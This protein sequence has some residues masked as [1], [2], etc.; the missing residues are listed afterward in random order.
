MEPN[1]ISFEEKER[2]TGAA[3]NL[4]KAR[5]PEY[6]PTQAN[7]DK[8]ISFIESQLGMSILEYPYPL[9]VDNFE[10]A[11]EHIL[12]TSWFY[13]REPEV[14]VEDPAVVKE[15]QAQE[16]VR[17][18]YDVQQA[19]AKMQRDRNMPLSELGKIVGVQNADFRAQR[20][21]NKL[22]VRSTGMESR[23]VEQVKLGIPAQAR[24]NVGLANPGLDTHSAEFTKKYAAELARLRG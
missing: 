5:H 12:A 19:A 3:A 24:V 6:W 2:L 23:R 16:R 11:Y 7:S 4:F 22:P 21:L 8:L 17:A 14:E 10:A 13:Q 1:R 18:E 9:Q 20:E 15:R